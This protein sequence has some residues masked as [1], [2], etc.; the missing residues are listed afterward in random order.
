MHLPTTL[1]P[2]N[3]RAGSRVE[4]G[5]LLPQSHISQGL[6]SLSK[7]RQSWKLNRMTVATELALE[8]VDREASVMP[9]PVL[10]KNFILMALDVSSLNH[11]NR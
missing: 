6:R 10:R 7:P 4:A 11:D 3:T 1:L 9:F 8:L 2:P 5:G